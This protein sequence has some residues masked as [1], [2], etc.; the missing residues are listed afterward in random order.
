MQGEERTQIGH[1]AH[2]GKVDLDY[3]RIEFSGLSN[4]NN[5]LSLN[6]VMI[7]IDKDGSY[8]FSLDAYYAEKS[9]LE[10]PYNGDEVTGAYMQMVKAGDDLLFKIAGHGG[11]ETTK[12]CNLTSRYEPIPRSMQRSLKEPTYESRRCVPCPFEAPFSGGFQN[13]ECRTCEWLFS[14]NIIAFNKIPQCADPSYIPPE[15]II[16]PMK[17]E[18]IEEDERTETFRFYADYEPLEKEEFDATPYLVFLAIVLP[19][20]A[21]FCIVTFCYRYTRIQKRVIELEDRN[22][23]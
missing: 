18:D 15:P 23:K 14:Y 1:S 13:T 22:K 6:A 2:I 16:E 10:V 11:I 4:K 3:L 8:T 17:P 21:I 20:L 12:A 19:I 9:L 7:S 5:A